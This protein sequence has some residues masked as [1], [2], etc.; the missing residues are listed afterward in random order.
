MRNIFCEWVCPIS[1]QR[2]QMCDLSIRFR[3]FGFAGWTLLFLTFVLRVYRAY[4]MLLMHYTSSSSTI[5]FG[6]PTNAPPFHCTY[7]QMFS[8]LWNQHTPKAP[9][10]TD[11]N[12]KVTSHWFILNLISCSSSGHSLW[13]AASKSW[14]IHAKE[15][16]Y[17]QYIGQRTR[18][19]LA[20]MSMWPRSCPPVG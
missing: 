3:S 2:Y 8:L 1:K 16:S 10:Y 14:W 9:P 12:D 6:I 4:Y 7:T 13:S 11:L 20:P 15:S 17:I 18:K 19:P 5:G